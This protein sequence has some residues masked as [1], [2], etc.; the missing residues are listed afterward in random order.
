MSGHGSYSKTYTEDFYN[1]ISKGKTRSEALTYAS[2]QRDLRVDNKSVFVQR[3]SFNLDSCK[4]LLPIRH[5]KFV[6][7]FNKN[8]CM[9]DF[10]SE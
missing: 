3:A 10:H 2:E 9:T 4:F 8:N 1:A 6:K 7:V 5:Y